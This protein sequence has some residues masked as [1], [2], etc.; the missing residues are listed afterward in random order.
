MAWQPLKVNELRNI[1]QLFKTLFL[2]TTLIGYIHV[3]EQNIHEINC[4]IFF[5][6]FTILIH[7]ACKY[8]K[9]FN[10]KIKYHKLTVIHDIDA[11]KWN[12]VQFQIYSPDF[13]NICNIATFNPYWEQYSICNLIFKFLLNSF[14]N[15]WC[16]KEIII[17]PWYSYTY[18]KNLS[19]NVWR[20]SSWTDFIKCVS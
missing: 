11:R 19:K 10:F 20:L 12:N 13:R 8:Q 9:N 5:H 3:L 15:N 2:A 14:L 17:I 16:R 6:I 4:Q 1:Q 7:W 18:P